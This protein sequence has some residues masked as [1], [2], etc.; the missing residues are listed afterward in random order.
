MFNNSIAARV[1]KV[2]AQR[3]ADAQKEHDTVCAE[4]DEQAET[5]KENHATLMVKKV[6]GIN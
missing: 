5:D 1:K 6:L 3:S 2:V 4:I